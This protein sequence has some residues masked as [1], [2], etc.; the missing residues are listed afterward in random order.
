MTSGSNPPTSS[1]ASDSSKDAVGGLLH[2]LM[3]NC[4]A[5]IN[6]ALSVAPPLLDG[7]H[8][9][10]HPIASWMVALAFG[11]EL[12]LAKRRQPRNPA[13]VTTS[14]IETVSE[15]TLAYAADAPQPGVIDWPL[16]KDLAYR[17]HRLLESHAGKALPVKATLGKRIPTGAGLGG[18]S[19]DAAAMLTGINQL[20]ELGISKQNLCTMSQSLGSD[21]TYL[22]AAVTGQPSALVTGLGEIITPWPLRQ[23]LHV[24]LIFPGVACPTGPVYKAF[25]LSCDQSPS[26]VRIADVE[27]VKSLINM[28]DQPAADLCAQLFNDLAEPAFSVQPILREIQRKASSH[29]GRAVHV[30]GSGATLFTLADDAVHAREIATSLSDVLNLPALATHTI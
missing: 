15:F 8:A 24:V 21:V 14:T 2:A 22:T 27:R 7:Q 29:I 13:R 20:F 23:T 17:A 1:N 25:D 18:G 9:G 10:M 12:M 16:E 19:S 11:D 6:L 30:T 3:L 26:A 28:A 4:P 5:K